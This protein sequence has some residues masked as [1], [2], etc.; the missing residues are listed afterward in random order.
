VKSEDATNLEELRQFGESVTLPALIITNQFS[1]HP[2]SP[3]GPFTLHIIS[4]LFQM[5]A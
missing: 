4:N 1:R 3:P 2:N 5:A